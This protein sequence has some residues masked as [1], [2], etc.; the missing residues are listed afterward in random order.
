MTD[1]AKMFAAA[2]MIFGAGL[3]LG[4]WGAVAAFGLWLVIVTRG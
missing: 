2:C 1:Y 3:T 4:S